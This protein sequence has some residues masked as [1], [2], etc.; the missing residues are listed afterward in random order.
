MR[1]ES[2]E[3]G[4]RQ[5]GIGLLTTKRSVPLNSIVPSLHARLEVK[6]RSML[7]KFLNPKPIMIR[8]ADMLNTCKFN[9]QIVTVLHQHSL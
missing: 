1:G 7:Q 6:L 2:E 5:L 3:A 4:I 9:T 8:K